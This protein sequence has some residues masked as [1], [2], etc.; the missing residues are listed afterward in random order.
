MKSYKVGLT[1]SYL[2]EI[3]AESLE[4]AKRS[5]E[6][7]TGDIKDISTRQDQANDKFSIEEIE[8]TVNEAFDV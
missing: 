7:Y 8:C 4:E 2:I 3:N 6:F 1:K 5:A